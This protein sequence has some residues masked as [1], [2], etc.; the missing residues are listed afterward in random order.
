MQQTQM[1]QMQQF[2]IQNI[3]RMVQ[4]IDLTAGEER[5]E[6]KDNTPCWNS[7]EE[8][9]EHKQGKQR[10][11][12]DEYIL[13]IEEESEECTICTD[14]KFKAEMVKGAKCSHSVCINCS[15]K[16][17]KC[18]FCREDFFTIGVSSG[19]VRSRNNSLSLREELCEI[20]RT[21]MYCYRVIKR[22]LVFSTNQF[23]DM[24]NEF[25][26]HD[27]TGEFSE[28]DPRLEKKVRVDSQIIITPFFTFA[29][30]K[31]ANAFVS[32]YEANNNHGIE[33]PFYKLIPYRVTTSNNTTTIECRHWVNETNMLII[34]IKA[35]QRPN[36]SVSIS[37][38]ATILR[39][40]TNKMFEVKK[41]PRFIG[42]DA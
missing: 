13:N 39:C 28:T 41:M 21:A 17:D 31:E 33:C 5:K 35:I 12:E 27:S 7:K 37:A 3:L 2:K 19:R 40:E 34:K 30:E 22:Q 42:L 24:Y 6:T 32:S 10:Q 20:S 4:L 26:S 23:F 9:E 8:Y 14:E 29:L 16:I 1:N 25:K 18:P 36:D 15:S 11:C 38:S